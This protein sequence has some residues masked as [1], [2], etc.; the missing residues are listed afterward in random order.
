MKH[1]F[2]TLGLWALIAAM[3]LFNPADVPE[4]PDNAHSVPVR[5][6]DVFSVGRMVCVDVDGYGAAAEDAAGLRMLGRVRNNVDA[7]GLEDGETR[8]V[9]DVGVFAFDNDGADPVTQAHYLR[10]VFVADDVT[11][12]AS[13]G[14]HNVVAGIC[15][16]FEGSKVWV[17]SKVLPS[18]AGWFGNH[19][20]A[21]FR[22]SANAAGV[23]IFQLYNATRALWQE[24]QLKGADGAETLVIA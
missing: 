22:I 20:D 15:R 8:V 12:S 2:L 11:V 4:R 16:G 5:A 24:V 21:N 9:F 10:P 1:L 6:D 19:P 7:T 3:T 23:P 13:P 17:D 18:I 14:S